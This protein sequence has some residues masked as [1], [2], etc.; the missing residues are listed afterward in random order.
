MA[1]IPASGGKQGCRSF[2]VVLGRGEHWRITKKGAVPMNV[3][4]AR[5]P[6]YICSIQLM[7]ILVFQLLHL[8]SAYL[9]R[10][11]EQVDKAVS[12]VMVIELACRE[13]CEGFAVE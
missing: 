9:Q 13:A 6:S 10:Q 1:G 12:V 2:H 5:R 4:L 3:H 8:H 11:A 7:C